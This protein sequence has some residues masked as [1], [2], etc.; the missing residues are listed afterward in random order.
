MNVLKALRGRLERLKGYDPNEARKPAGEGGGQWTSGGDGGGGGNGAGYGS[1]VKIGDRSG[2][3]F[4]GTAYRFNREGLRPAADVFWARE[5]D[6][7]EAF[8]EEVGGKGE[9]VEGQVSLTNPLHVEATPRQFTDPS[10]ENPIIKKAKEEGRDGIIFEQ[11]DNGDELYVVFG[12]SSKAATVTITLADVAEMRRR[13]RKAFDPDEPRDEGGQW[14]SGGGGAAGTSAPG[15]SQKPRRRPVRDDKDTL[16]LMLSHVDQSNAIHGDGSFTTHR[17]DQGTFFRDDGEGREGEN[18]AVEK[19]L[20]DLIEQGTGEKVYLAYSTRLG[21]SAHLY[22]RGELRGILSEEKGKTVLSSGHV[23]G[24]RKVVLAKADSDEDFRRKV[25]KVLRA[26]KSLPAR[27]AALR[28]RLKAFDPNE[29]RDEAGRWT[30]GGGE[31]GGSAHEQAHAAWKARQA[32]RD[33]RREA[34]DALAQH[35]QSATRRQGE[36]VASAGKVAERA[37]AGKAAPEELADALGTTLDV[38]RRTWAEGAALLA[39]AGATAKELLGHKGACERAE[40]DIGKRADAYSA[41]DG[42]A[43]EAAAEF[44]RLTEAEPADEPAEPQDPDED[45]YDTQ[46]AYDAAY[47]EYEQ[48][49]DA[50]EDAHGEWEESHDKWQ[51]AYEHAEDRMNGTAGR[52]ED[53]YFKWAGAL[54]EHA[55]RISGMESKIG[56]AAEARLGSEEEADPEP[57]EE[58]PEEEDEEDEE[59]EDDEGNEEG[60]HKHLAAL[61]VRLKAVAARPRKGYDPNEPRDE[62]GK[63]TG[64]GDSGAGIGGGNADNG[65]M[66][67]SVPLATADDLHEAATDVAPRQLRAANLVGHIPG[68]ARLVQEIADAMREHGWVGPPLLAVKDG[69]DWQAWTGSHR[70]AAAGRAD[71]DAVPVVFVQRGEVEE[72]ARAAGFDTAEDDV[73]EGLDDEQKWQ[74]LQHANMAYASERAAAEIMRLEVSKH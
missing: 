50:W 22:H 54:D 49:Y 58:E 12:V 66:D 60:L 7:A 2:K 13:L 32:S 33:T 5:R 45:E 40:A 31:G 14:T 10:F 9:I 65:G 61:R 1:H 36:A 21:G 46:S 48:D 38:H 26:G 37:S 57:E 25:R 28:A 68:S 51:A 35:A 27:L 59:E 52:A 30:E 15:E 24:G 47:A 71:L 62:A 73:F 23:S 74:V 41:A 69:D 44:D 18:E 29:P 43:T 6:Y 39:A 20:V 56:E 42:K 4:S 55:T 67:P 8:A 17:P 64:G 72:W 19:R 53:A 63:W 16:Q 11:K 3:P 34:V 70:L